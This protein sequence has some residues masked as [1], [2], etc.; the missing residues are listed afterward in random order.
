MRGDILLF[1][2][3][4]AGVGGG[5]IVAVILLTGGGGGDGTCSRALPPL[6]ESEI[7]QL[8]FQ[9]E[10]VG[11]T[12]VIQAASVGNLASAESAFFGPVHNFT[13]NV[14]PDLRAVDEGLAVELCEAVIRIEDELIP[15]IDIS[16]GALEATT[17]RNLL[18]DA[19]EALD[20]VRP[21][22]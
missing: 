22:E 8:G 1:L 4:V 17:I 20:F 16:R 12:R 3:L 11:L 15:P 18:R 21:G 5:V 7:T 19:A 6:G 9:A 13:H 14:D 2:G 10:D